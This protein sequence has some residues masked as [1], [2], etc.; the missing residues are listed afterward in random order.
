MTAKSQR[1]P[2]F[3][4]RDETDAFDY[5]AAHTKPGE[6]VL[7]SFQT[8]NAL[9]AWAGVRVVIGHGPESAG[10]TELIP[11]VQE[12]Y[13]P[14]IPDSE[15]LRLFDLWDVVY[16]FQ[17]PQEA[18]MGDWDPNQAG[19]LLREFQTGAYEVFRVLGR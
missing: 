12:V 15:R 1:I 11:L 18:A 7:S 9:P 16:L 2:V 10:L 14:S 4:P 3:L 8:G 13:D 19:Y 5:I 6:V 17:G